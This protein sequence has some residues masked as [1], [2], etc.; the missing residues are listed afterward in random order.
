MVDKP[1]TADA[2]ALAR[3]VNAEPWE[4]PARHGEA[5]LPAVRL[6]VRGTGRRGVGHVALP[7]LCRGGTR[8]A[9]KLA[10]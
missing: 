6:L 2:E 3:A 8:P 9:P 5:A 10:R 1:E 4:P 7:G